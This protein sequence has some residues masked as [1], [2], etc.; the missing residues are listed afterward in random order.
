MSCDL[1]A[2]ERT[3]LHVR[4]DVR[5]LLMLP[6]DLVIAHPPC[7]ELAVSRGSP[8]TG[9]AMGAAVELVV[10]CYRS[11][12]PRVA[13]E[14]P[15]VFRSVRR[16]L[17]EPDC[18]VEPYE[19]GADYRKRTYLWLRGLPPLL[20]TV[21]WAG[22]PLGKLVDTD[23]SGLHRAPGRR[24]RFHEGM[25]TAMAEQWSPLPRGAH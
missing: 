21:A 4:G 11:N 3:G 1:L 24:S 13:V 16:M 2:S 12:A 5:P 9:E 10:D 6:W 20:P 8:G 23:G 18:R 17:G 25:A 14:Q 15:R 19:F 22:G 7:N